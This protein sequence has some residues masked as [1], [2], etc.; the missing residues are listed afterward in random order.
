[1]L[2]PNRLAMTSY[3]IH[4]AQN[5]FVVF[6]VTTRQSRGGSVFCKQRRVNIHEWLFNL[7]VFLQTQKCNKKINIMNFCD[8]YC[9]IVSSLRGCVC[10]LGMPSALSTSESNVAYLTFPYTFFCSRF[11]IFNHSF[12]WITSRDFMNDKKIYDCSFCSDCSWLVYTFVVMHM[13]LTLGKEQCNK[14][15][16]FPVSFVLDHHHHYHHHQNNAIL[17]FTCLLHVARERE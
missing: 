9:T 10:V 15:N 1:M 17:D 8:R 2:L 7:T 11:E 3:A 14:L 16:N 12:L 13:M 4:C 5:G 6:S